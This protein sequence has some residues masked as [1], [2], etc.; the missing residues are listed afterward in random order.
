MVGQAT[1]AATAR[2]RTSTSTGWPAWASE[3]PGLLDP[4]FAPDAIAFVEWPEQAGDAW[5]AERVAARV[6]LAHAGGDRRT[7]EV[8]R[9]VILG[10]DTA[11]PATAV[12]AARPAAAEIERRDD[13]A[14]GSAPATPRGCSCWS[15]GARRRERRLGGRR[16]HRRRRRSRGLHRAAHGHR[17]R[18]RLAQARGI[19]LVGVSSLEALAAGAP[20]TRARRACSRCIDARRGEVFAA[21]W[22]DGELVLEPRG[23]SRPARSRGRGAPRHAG[24][25][26][27]GG[28][29]PHRARTRRACGPGGRFPRPPRQRR[30][31]SAGSAARGAPGTGTRSSPSTPRARRR[32]PDAVTAPDRRR[33]DIRR[34]TYAD[35]PQVIA[36]ERR[37]FPTPWSLAMFVLELSKPSGV[38]LAAPRTARL[39]GL[40]I[41]SRY[42]TVWHVMNVAVDPSA[43]G[44]VATALLSALYA[45]LRPEARHAGGPPLQRAARSP[46]TSAWAFAPPACA[47]ATTRTTARTRS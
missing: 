3:D 21:A 22:R 41:C 25:G 42:D 9:A 45:R 18:P 34:L 17:D 7:I 11:T 28:T 43:G 4:F 19:P 37:A 38:C 33:P 46:S 32:A 6:R 39:V 15:G 8:R 30:G 29:I 10:L 31:R 14:P 27:R 44:A 35:L 47:A 16:A 13:P 26:G 1:T 40:H 36:I 2:S 12:G 5:P 24:R 20:A 23:R